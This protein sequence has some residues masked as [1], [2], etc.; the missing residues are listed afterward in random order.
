VNQI[1]FVALLFRYA[2]QR[3]INRIQW[4]ALC[5]LV[6]GLVVSEL[7]AL[8]PPVTCPPPLNTTL[9]YVSSLPGPVN[10]TSGL[11]LPF[12]LS[13]GAGGVVSSSKVPAADIW[14]AF[15]LVCVMC[16]CSAVG[17][18]MIEHLYKTHS[19][20]LLLQNVQLY[21][22][23]AL[24]NLLC[25]VVRDRATVFGA[26]GPFVGFTPIVWLIILFASLSG[27]SIAFIL[28]YSDNIGNVWAH[29]ASL[30]LTALVSAVLFNFDITLAFVCG[31]VIVKLCGYLYHASSDPV[32]PT[33]EYQPVDTADSMPRQH[34]QHSADVDLVPLED[35]FDPR[36]QSISLH[37][38]PPSTKGAKSVRA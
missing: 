26:D 22:W 32:G 18:I 13:T 9:N 8:H 35:D 4:I 16:F 34:A 25:L 20:H 27:L 28:K 6:V 19:H 7:D 17:N 37:S 24:L 2:L 33:S 1:I 30:V 23:G 12:Q 5:L 36:M 29:A 31:C 21:G 14:L 15:V 3:T 38:V 10:S 11:H